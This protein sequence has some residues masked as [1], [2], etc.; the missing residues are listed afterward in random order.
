MADQVAISH[1]LTQLVDKI[2]DIN[3]ASLTTVD[4]RGK[5][6][7]RPMYTTQSDEDGTLWFFCEKDSEK[8][9]EIR[10]NPEVNLGYNSQAQDTYVA[11]TGQAILVNDRQ[12][13]QDLW[14]EGLRG[15]FPRA[16]TT[17]TSRCCAWTLRTASSGTCPATPCCGPTPTPRP[18]PPA[19]GTSP[20]PRSRP[21][22]CRNRPLPSDS[23]KKRQPLG[24][25][26]RG[27]ISVPPTAWPPPHASRRGIG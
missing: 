19:S 18:W 22:C 6:H 21:R 5:L 27:L 3:V 26:F 20:A 2:K 15:F 23:K 10:R 14:S 12:R 8:V 25:L 24:R 9:Q 4:A 16:P 17:P 13:I 11:I 1:D 7:S